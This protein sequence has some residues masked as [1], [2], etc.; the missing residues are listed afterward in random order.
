MTNFTKKLTLTLALGLAAATTTM[1]ARADDS[2]SMA[3]QRVVVT[4]HVQQDKLINIDQ[5]DSVKFT[6]N[7]IGYTLHID[8]SAGAAGTDLST[9]GAKDAQLEGVHVYVTQDAVARN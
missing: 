2:P 3:P 5:G 8:K 9:V 4:G 6:Q 7:G 1:A